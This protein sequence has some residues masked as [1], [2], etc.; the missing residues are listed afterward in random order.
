MAGNLTDI[1]FSVHGENGTEE[2]TSRQLDQFAALYK[3]DRLINGRYSHLLLLDLYLSEKHNGLSPELVVQEINALESGSHSYM[4]PPTK[5]H[6]KPLRGLWHKHFLLVTPSSMAQNILNELGKNGT[7]Q[8]AEAAFSSDNGDKI[9]ADMIS[10]FV[11]RIVEEPFSKRSEQ[12]KL[13]GEWLIYAE[14][15][16]QKYYLCLSN[17]KHAQDRS[18]EHVANRLKDVCCREFDWLNSILHSQS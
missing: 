3:I 8:A 12:A 9:T 6:R 13:T 14:H 15:D 18:D 7:K 1:V 4:K 5:F 11:S 17:H 10:D 2:I 16:G